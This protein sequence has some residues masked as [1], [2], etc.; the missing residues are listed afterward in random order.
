MGNNSRYVI[1]QKFNRLVVV[2]ELEERNPIGHIMIECLCDCGKT[3][4]VRKASVTRGATASCGC[5]RIELQRKTTGLISLIEN[6][7]HYR[8]SARRRG[9]EFLLTQEQF[10]SIVQSD[11]FYCGEPPRPFNRYY[12]LDGSLRKG[13]TS[14]ESADRAWV[15]IN[16]VDRW[17]NS[18]GYTLENS[19]PCCPECNESKMA[20]SADSFISRAEKI[21]EHQR[22]LRAKKAS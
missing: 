21:T 7:C 6:F 2:R 4:T 17:D 13:R 22:A 10:I 3:T 5:Y 11:C 18:L 20:K 16:G 1:G 9:Y 8:S 14:K 12:K 15:K 19:V